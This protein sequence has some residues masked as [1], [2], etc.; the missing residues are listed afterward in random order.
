MIQEQIINIKSNVPYY[1]DLK[2]LKASHISQFPLMTK[3][4][5]RNNYE[6][7]I[8]DHLRDIKDELLDYLVNPN[9]KAI[10]ADNE[11]FYSSDI[12]IEE[13]TGT[14]GVPFRCFKTKK[15]R[16]RLSA[17][18]WKQRWGIDKGVTPLNL[19]Q[20]SHIQLNR[21]KPDVYN[22]EIDN[23]VKIYNEIVQKKIRWIH[24]TPVI[25]L[26]HIEVLRESSVFFDFSNLKYIELCGYFVNEEIKKVIQHFFQA[27][28]VNQYG[29]IET[30]PMAL[31]YDL[32]HLHIN[33]RIVYLELVTD[34]GEV[35]TEENKIGE[36][37]VT[38]LI[39]ENFPFIRY[40]TGDYAYYDNQ[41]RSNVIECNC[42]K[43]VEG[44]ECNLIRGLDKRIMGNHIFKKIIR[45]IHYRLNIYDLKYIQIIQEK[46]NEL[47][48]FVNRINKFQKFRSLFERATSQELGIS[49][50]FHYTFLTKD[51]L[52]LKIRE[53]P[54]LFLSRISSFEV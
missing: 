39:N 54:N 1:Q 36:I 20:F 31:G 51:E 7:F 34:T 25:L 3:E 23:L 42:I 33:D 2:F 35:I 8:S 11:L 30:W 24:S 5:I 38:T 27:D 29:S 32:G 19:F 26:R 6:L 12:I 17:E 15:E 45:S 41:D 47:H 48:I 16:M 18:I 40:R 14:S 43:L 9:V 13:T 4:F 28:I 10:R 49:W 46:E 53:K 21:V 22:F 52:D 44:R 37:V 50:V